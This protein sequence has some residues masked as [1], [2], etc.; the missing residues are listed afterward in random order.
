MNTKR[1]FCL[2][3]ITMMLVFTTAASFAQVRGNG[4]I[5]KEERQL[6]GFKAISVRNA[7]NLQ[8][9]QGSEE[10]VTVEADENILPFLKT[11]VAE[12]ELKI[13]IKGSINNSTAL[14]VFV[15]VKQLSSL[16]SSS[17]AR[18]ETKGKIESNEMRVSSSSGSAVQ[19]EV[20]CT[21]LKIRL[22]S[23]SANSFSGSATNISVES[24][25]GSALS[26]KELKAEKGE[27]D[28][29]SG[30][31]IV[32]NVTR[33]VRA[34]ASS[35]AQISVSGNPASRDSDSSSGGSVSFK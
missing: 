5:V 14:N 13:F 2:A 31:V 9:R 12:G 7:I 28:A 3:A 25:S 30:A 22:S 21:E 20:A 27:L 32:V 6:S 35:G 17:A 16:E 15:T 34:R 4:K 33:E 26:A 8:I 1:W 19:M 18:V 24:S 29:S 23:G 10:K 11:E